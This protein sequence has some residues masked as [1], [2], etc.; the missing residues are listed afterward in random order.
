M[1]TITFRQ[2]NHADISS[3]V[4]LVESAYRGDASRVGWTT[5]AN[6]LEGQRIDAEGVRTAI[7]LPNSLV[8]LASASTPST[9]SGAEFSGT[10]SLLACC[11]LEKK[12][13]AVYFG[14]FSVK[15][16]SQGTGIGKAVLVEAER[17]AIS[18]WQCQRMEMTVIDIRDELIA[19]YIRHGYHRTGKHLPF[20]Y[21]D[22]RF[23][24]PLRDDLRFEVL[25]KQLA[26]P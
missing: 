8:L 13:Q 12:D 14:M 21:G 11:H 23:G 25:E 19:F 3:I 22:E 17:L 18:L 16:A 1:S 4:S 20:P 24:I 10:N 9:S 7:D 6:I 5:E 2:A 15:P 26:Y